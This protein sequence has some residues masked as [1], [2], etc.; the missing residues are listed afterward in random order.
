MQDNGGDVM[1]AI[2][3]LAVLAAALLTGCTGSASAPADPSPPASATA[4]PA[5]SP[6]GTGSA[7]GCVTSDAMGQCGPYSYPANTA[8]SGYNTYV[9]QDVFN[10]ISGWR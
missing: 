5:P 4:S 1:K 7:A 10:R 6:G 9:G 3:V 2:R 8:S